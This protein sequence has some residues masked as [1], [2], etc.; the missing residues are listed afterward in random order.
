MAKQLLQLPKSALDTVAFLFWCSAIGLFVCVSS[1]VFTYLVSLLPSRP[2]PKPRQISTVS[3]FP[4]NT[5]PSYR[6]TTESNDTSIIEKNNVTNLF[7]DPS[8][9]TLKLREVGTYRFILPVAPRIQPVNH[10]GVVTR[11]RRVISPDVWSQWILFDYTKHK[12]GVRYG[13]DSDAVFFQ[14]HFAEG[15]ISEPL[16][17]SNQKMLSA[18]RYIKG[19]RY[20]NATDHPVEIEITLSYRHR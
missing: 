12:V 1:P 6:S 18:N 4:N 9:T 17:S 2:A 8:A 13:S 19:F 15:D 14:W 5:T 16:P 7:Y 11:P 10:S 20:R 3:T